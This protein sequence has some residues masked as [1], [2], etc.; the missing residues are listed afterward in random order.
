MFHSCSESVSVVQFGGIVECIPMR[1][2]GRGV[3]WLI[4]TIL[5]LK[6]KHISVESGIYE[7]CCKNLKFEEKK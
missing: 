4:G 2:V 1:F 7:G 6:I 5:T 3:F